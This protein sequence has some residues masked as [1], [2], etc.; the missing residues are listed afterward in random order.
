MLSNREYISVVRPDFVRDSRFLS[1]I[2]KD[3]TRFIAYKPIFV[4][5]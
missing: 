4:V 2:R 5:L 1:K 3:M